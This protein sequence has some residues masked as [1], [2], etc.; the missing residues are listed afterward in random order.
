MDVLTLNVALRLAQLRTALQ[1]ADKLGAAPGKVCEKL[2]N[3]KKGKNMVFHLFFA[4]Q[5]QIE[6]IS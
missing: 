1:L 4:H 3:L 6:N 5:L 2:R